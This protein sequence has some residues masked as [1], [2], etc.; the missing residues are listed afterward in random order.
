VKAND[1][2]M[3]TWALAAIALAMVGLVLTLSL[4]PDPLPYVGGA[5]VMAAPL[6]AFVGLVRDPSRKAAAFA[7]GVALIPLALLVLALYVVATR[8]T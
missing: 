5:M 2:E 4:P 3:E 1:E 7:L 6:C 8:S